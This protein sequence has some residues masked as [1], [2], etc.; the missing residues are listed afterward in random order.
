[1]RVNPAPFRRALVDEE[2]DPSIP[3]SGLYNTESSPG[4]SDAMNKI[5]FPTKPIPIDTSTSYI[6]FPIGS[7]DHAASPTRMLNRSRGPNTPY[8]DFE[9]A[10]PFIRSRVQSKLDPTYEAEPGWRTRRESTASVLI[11]LNLI[12]FSH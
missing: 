7:P 6:Q 11:F 12:P 9:V 8:G 3:P 5:E 2:K 4:P 1:V 10:T